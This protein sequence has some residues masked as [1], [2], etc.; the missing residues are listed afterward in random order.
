MY[1][2]LHTTYYVRYIIYH[3]LGTVYYIPYVLN[4]T[5]RD[6]FLLTSHKAD[7]RTSRFSRRRSSR[8]TGWPAVQAPADPN[9]FL[10]HPHT[11]DI[12]TFIYIIYTY[13]MYSRYICIHMFVYIHTHI[14]WCLVFLHIMYLSMRLSISLSTYLSIYLHL[15]I[16][17][18]CSDSV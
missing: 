18:C 17:L 1:C 10:Q 3:I 12:C 11:Y 16:A 5:R 6:P 7:A 2:I 8:Q 4:Y 14:F 9:R 13:I 15:S